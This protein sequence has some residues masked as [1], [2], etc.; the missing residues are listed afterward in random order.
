MYQIYCNFPR[1]MNRE[2]NSGAHNNPILFSVKLK[3]FSTFSSTNS[4]GLKLG[5][6]VAIGSNLSLEGPH[7]HFE[8]NENKTNHFY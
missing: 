7:Y 3:G 4:M 8:Y 2:M 5:K 6:Y 1:I